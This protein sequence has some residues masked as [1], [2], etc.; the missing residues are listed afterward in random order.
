MINL[1]FQSVNSFG[2]TTT[3]LQESNLHPFATKNSIIRNLMS[4]FLTSVCTYNPPTHQPYPQTPTP[5]PKTPNPKP[6]TPNIQRYFTHQIPY[7]AK[8]G[9][10][11][12]FS[13]ISYQLQK[14]PSTEIQNLLCNTLLILCAKFQF[15]T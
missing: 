10:N 8:K 3:F 4:K 6:K 13:Y 14:F 15:N 9:A 12:T 2:T 7:D 5:N 11:L 1:I